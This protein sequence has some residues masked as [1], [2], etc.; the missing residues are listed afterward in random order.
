M[1]VKNSHGVQTKGSGVADPVIDDWGGGNGL[2]G[3]SCI[4][5]NT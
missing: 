5:W 2:S 4:P 1:V 3:W